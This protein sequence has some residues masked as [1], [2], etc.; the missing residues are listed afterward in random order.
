MDSNLSLQA[1]I[2]KEFIRPK[3]F[4]SD[5]KVEDFF[6]FVTANNVLVAVESSQSIG[7]I[8]HYGSLLFTFLMS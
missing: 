5:K 8:E 6:S 2:S 4:S 3:D 7:K 1:E